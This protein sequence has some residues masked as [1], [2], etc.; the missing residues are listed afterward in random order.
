MAFSNPIHQAL[1]DAVVKP[2]LHKKKHNVEG[3]IQHVD[4][5]DQTARIYWRDPES[6]AEREQADV[7][8]PVSSDGIIGRSLEAGDRVMLS[9]KNGNQAKPQIIGI[10]QKMAGTDYSSRSGAGIPKGINFF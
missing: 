9:F 8:I 6:G 1:Y 7:P 4:Y 10:Q 2:A 3:S 5:Y